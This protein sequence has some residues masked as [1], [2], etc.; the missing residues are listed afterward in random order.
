MPTLRQENKN[1]YWAWKSMKQRC[2]NQKCHAY[3]NYGARGINICDEWMNFEPFYYWAIENGYQKGLELD[4]IDNNGPYAPDNCRWTTRHENLNNRRMTVYLT[5][6]GVTLP[7]TEWAS[8]IGIDR[9]II[10]LWIETHG[11]NYAVFR[12]EEA[13]EN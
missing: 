3:H 9:H 2:L 12:I 4:R 13:L 8:K 5:V 10:Y 1:I 11:I 6:N 7:A